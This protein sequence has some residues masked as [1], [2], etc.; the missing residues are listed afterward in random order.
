MSGS[1]T[2]NMISAYFQDALPRAFFAGMFQARPENFHTSEE[3]EIDIVRSEED[4]AI[5]VQDISTG[6]RLNSDDLFTNKKFKPPIFKEAFPVNS[7]ELMKRMPGEDPFK[8]PNFRGNLILRMFRGMRLVEAKIRRTIELQASQIMQTGTVTLTDSNGVALYT[9]NYVPKSTHFPTA[10]TSWA[11]ATLA[12][13]ISDLTSLADVIRGDGL[14]DPDQLI[15]GATAW[16]NLL[17]TSGFLARFDAQRANLGA[18]AP[19]DRQGNGGIYRGTLELGNYKLDV[20]TYAGRYKHPQTGVSTPFL[21]PG[22]IIVRSSSARMDATFG[23][24]PNIGALLNGGGSQLLPEL[25]SR[26][27]SSA[28]GMDITSNVWLT[29]DGET[30]MGGVGSRPLLIPTA[31]DTYGCLTTQL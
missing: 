10:G 20:W 5:V 14:T 4:V 17:Q 29:G 22:K 30:L 2:I 25:P 6:Y 3:V 23:A 18:I 7:Y 24:I 31:I 13:K 28:A 15:I 27:S 1:T 12:Q 9:L 19:M 26:L 8:S 11:T 21:A 16:E